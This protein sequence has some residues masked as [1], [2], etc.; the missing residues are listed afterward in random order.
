VWGDR[1]YHAG[2]IGDRSV[3]ITSAELNMLATRSISAWVKH[4]RIPHSLGNI[5]GPNPSTGADIKNT[6][7]VLK[8]GHKKLS[9]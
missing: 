7:R 4:S 8:G 2:W 1:N 6:L 5:Y 3:L 9:A